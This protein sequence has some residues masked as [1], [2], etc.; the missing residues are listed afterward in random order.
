MGLSIRG[1]SKVDLALGPRQHA[2]SEQTQHHR[3]TGKPASKSVTSREEV[4]LGRRL[5]APSRT[6]CR[7]YCNDRLAMKGEVADATRRNALHVVI[8]VLSRE[9]SELLEILYN[10]NA[11]WHATVLR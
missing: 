5:T 4:T 8:Y 11:H 2:D 6:S 3:D 10:A 9:R 7:I 1:R